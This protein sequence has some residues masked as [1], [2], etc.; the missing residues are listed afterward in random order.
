M[1]EALINFIDNLGK[2]II[3]MSLSIDIVLPIMFMGICFIIFALMVM[4]RDYKMDKIV[5]RILI[6]EK[7]LLQKE[8]DKKKK[9]NKN[10]RKE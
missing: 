7:V 3:I 1:W 10:G 2:A 6:L 5:M 4:F 8:L 9:E